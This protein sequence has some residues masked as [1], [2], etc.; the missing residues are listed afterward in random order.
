MLSSNC[1]GNLPGEP[2]S[3]VKPESLLARKYRQATRFSLGHYFVQQSH[4]GIQGLIESAFLQVNSI[5][6]VV[7]AGGKFG[8]KPSHL[9]DDHLC[10]L[11]EE[12]LIESQLLAK[13]NRPPQYPPQHIAPA[14]VGGDYSV[15]D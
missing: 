4:P 9:L 12:R 11:A 5:D 6:D 13:E 1:G 2:V 10:Y 14:L 7:L 8:V 15:G 3:I